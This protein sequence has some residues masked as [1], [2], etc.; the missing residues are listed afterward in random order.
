MKSITIHGLNDQISQKI[1][2]TAQNK[3]QSLNKT[4]KELLEKALGL[5]PQGSKDYRNDFSEFLGVWSEEDS[6]EFETSIRDFEKVDP[7]AWK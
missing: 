5:T 1:T 7:G 4:I 3:G 6:K 2:E